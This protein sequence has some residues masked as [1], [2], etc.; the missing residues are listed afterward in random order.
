MTEILGNDFGVT[1][2]ELSLGLSRAFADVVEF[3]TR[4]LID[5][6]ALVSGLA[7][8]SRDFRSVARLR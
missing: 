3:Q 6:G 5:S 8:R 7:N 2:T 1:L 4:R